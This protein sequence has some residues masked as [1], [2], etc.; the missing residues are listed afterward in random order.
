VCPYY[1]DGELLTRTSAYELGFYPLGAPAH[2]WSAQKR[3]PKGTLGL[4]QFSRSTEA[5][6]GVLPPA[7]SE[8]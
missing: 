4:M 1:L 3:P 2:R 5:T 6:H 8:N 7:V